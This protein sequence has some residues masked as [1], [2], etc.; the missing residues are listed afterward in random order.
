MSDSAN[1]LPALT[2]EQRRANLEKATA[3]RKE[4]KALL[5][6]VRQGSVTFSACDISLFRGGHIRLCRRHGPAPLSLAGEGAA[7]SSP[8]YLID[9]ISRVGVHAFPTPPLL[10]P[11]LPYVT[12]A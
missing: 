8:S 7:A 4:R 10:T 1:K 9:S 2:D 12:R 3:V 6:L 11:F 5:D